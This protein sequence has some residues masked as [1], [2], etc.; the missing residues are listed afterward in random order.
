[1]QQLLKAAWTE[2][3]RERSMAQMVTDARLFR[4]LVMVAIVVV[5]CV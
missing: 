5:A 1:M 2:L 3:N 4:E